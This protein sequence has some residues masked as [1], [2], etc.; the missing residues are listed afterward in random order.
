MFNIYG[1]EHLL[2]QAYQLL[3][4]L[5]LVIADCRAERFPF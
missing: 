2:E 4:V 3:S 1:D 5:P